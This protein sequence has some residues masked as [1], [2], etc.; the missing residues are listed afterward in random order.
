MRFRLATMEIGSEATLTIL[1]QR[2]QLTLTIKLASAPETPPAQKTTLTGAQPL[3]GATVAN[4][5]P[6]LADQLQMNNDW[7][8][9]VIVQ[10]KRGST[11]HRFGLAAGD[12]IAAINGQPITSVDDLQAALA[13]AQSWQISFR[14]DGVT[15]TLKIE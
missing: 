9:V 4:L 6:A 8:G 7:K 15:R 1:R 14:R 3:S 10:I 13:D 2:Q 12:I 5:S 11:A